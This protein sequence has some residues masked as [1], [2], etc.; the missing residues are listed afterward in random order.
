[1]EY[2]KDKI[3]ENKKDLNGQEENIELVES[4]IISK[5]E[6]DSMHVK[7]GLKNPQDEMQKLEGSI[8][9]EQG[10]KNPEENK[11]NPEESLKIQQY[12][13]NPNEEKPNV[14]NKDEKMILINDQSVEN[15][16]NEKKIFQAV[17]NI[18]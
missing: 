15:K 12:L 14:E 18:S 10:H 8:K 4:I 9:I 3:M 13:K 6:K 11:Q 5:K 17:S 16:V 1:M 7:Q 2:P